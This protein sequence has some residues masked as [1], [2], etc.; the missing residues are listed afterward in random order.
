MS[1]ENWSGRREML[2]M[3]PHWNKNMRQVSFNRT[4]EGGKDMCRWPMQLYPRLVHLLRGP[5]MCRSIDLIR[6]ICDPRLL[7]ASVAL[8]CNFVQ[9]LMEG[10]KNVCFQWGA[11][12]GYQRHCVRF[13]RSCVSSVGKYVPG[14]LCSRS[15]CTQKFGVCILDLRCDC[16]SGPSWHHPGAVMA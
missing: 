10:T 3:G 2:D 13:V 6:D 7:G 1:P 5:I 14:N 4:P 8:H 15:L 9:S 16:M 12:P 11:V